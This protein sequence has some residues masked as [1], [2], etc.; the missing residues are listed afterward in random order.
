MT[1]TKAMNVASGTVCSPSTGSI[2]ARTPIDR[3][4]NIEANV[5]VGDK[6]PLVPCGTAWRLIILLV[7]VSNDPISE[8]KV[9]EQATAT[10]DD[11]AR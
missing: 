5:P 7:L 2:A 11:N 4:P 9:S 10:H 8:A 3:A 6:P 1:D